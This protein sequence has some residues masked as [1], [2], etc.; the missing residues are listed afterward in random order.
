MANIEV[1]K[2]YIRIVYPISII[3]LKHYQKQN[4]LF[5]FLVHNLRVILS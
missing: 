4:S 3:Y 1:N 5:K 2:K